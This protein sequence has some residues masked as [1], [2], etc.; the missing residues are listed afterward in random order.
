ML[1]LKN[2][3]LVL[4]HSTS[5]KQLIM[6]AS[7]SYAHSHAGFLDI[8]PYAFSLVFWSFL[9]GVLGALICN[10]I[11]F[12]SKPVANHKQIQELNN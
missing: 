2:Y 3:F 10:S 4:P 9:D 8:F 1:N 12:P 5:G 6:M 7:P 11:L